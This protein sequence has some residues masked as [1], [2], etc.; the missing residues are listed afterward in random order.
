MRLRILAL[1]LMIGGCGKL[2]NPVAIVYPPASVMFVKQ[3][4]PTTDINAADTVS[5]AGACVAYSMYFKDKN[6]LVITPASFTANF[7][8]TW[9]ATNS[10]V[11]TRSAQSSPAF[12]TVNFNDSTCGAGTS[13][14]DNTTGTAIANAFSSTTYP[15]PFSINGNGANQPDSFTLTLTITGITPNP[16][17]TV[18]TGP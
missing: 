7:A 8:N 15:F 18:T 16:V 13:I 4:D 5:A 17:F 3:S 12:A 6:G 9:W 1:A 10:L 14:A 2:A 11:I